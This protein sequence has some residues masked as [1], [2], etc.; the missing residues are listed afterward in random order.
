MPQIASKASTLLDF[1]SSFRVG[2]GF[3]SRVAAQEG[4]GLCGKP[5]CNLC[6]QTEQV[7][8]V[9]RGR[10]MEHQRPVAVGPTR[11]RDI[12]GNTITT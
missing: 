3:T 7:G 8:P 4:L 12:C 2:G 5:A 11:Q 9:W 10:L 1:L 6:G